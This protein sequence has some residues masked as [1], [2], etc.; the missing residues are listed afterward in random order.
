MTSN[1]RELLTR[2]AASG[3]ALQCLANEVDAFRGKIRAVAFD[4]F[5]ILDSRPVFALVDKLYPEKGVELST[6]WRERQGG[7]Y[8]TDLAGASLGCPAAVLLL[9]WIDAP[10]AI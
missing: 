6:L 9:S 5:P 4:A 8:F 1:R 7:V 3:L 2:M 10:S